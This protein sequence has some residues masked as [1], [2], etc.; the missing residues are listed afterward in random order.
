MSK[1]CHT[2]RQSFDRYSD[3]EKHTCLDTKTMTP[4]PARMLAEKLCPKCKVCKRTV[5]FYLDRNEACGL[6]GW[7]KECQKAKNK[8]PKARALSLA[9]YRK[10]MENPLEHQK[11]CARSE[12]RRVVRLGR[13]I[14]PIACSCGSSGK[15]QAHHN[16]YSKPYEVVWACPPCHKEIHR[17]DKLREKAGE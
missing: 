14:K 7:C 2:C 13:I 12:L 10:R 15:I 8:T 3:L 11:M 6:S 1:H 5:D 4:S 16:D 9:R 17:A